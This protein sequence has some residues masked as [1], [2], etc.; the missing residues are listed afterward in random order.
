MYFMSWVLRRYKFLKISRQFFL[1]WQ[2]DMWESKGW[3]Q[4]HCTYILSYWYTR[5][6]GYS[7]LEIK[8]IF[9]QQTAV[10]DWI[11]GRTCKRCVTIVAYVRF[12]VFTAVTMKNASSGMWHRVDLVWTDC[13]HL[14]TLVPRSRIFLPWRWRR[15]VPPKR[16]FTQDLHGILQLLFNYLHTPEGLT[17]SHAYFINSYGTRIKFNYL[18]VPFSRYFAFGP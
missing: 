13:S 5:E 2:Y 18:L 10:G 14:L 6:L 7:S 1:R 4:R 8:S 3:E 16:R 9:V 12:E 11:N 17:F 15:Y